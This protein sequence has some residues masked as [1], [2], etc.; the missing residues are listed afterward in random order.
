MNTEDQLR[1]IGD[2]LQRLVKEFAQLQKENER[3]KGELHAANQKGELHAKNTEVLK[4]QVS[5]LKLNTAEMSDADKKEFEKKIN[6]YLK[7]IDR[8][9]DLLGQ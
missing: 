3:L 7:E 4:Q 8:C 1:R 2:K 5:I 6:V 9:I